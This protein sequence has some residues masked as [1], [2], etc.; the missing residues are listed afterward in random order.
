MRQIWKYPLEFAPE[1]TL[2]LPDG[3]IVRHAGFQRDTLCLWVEV[4]D[5]RA[6]PAEATVW[7]HATGDEVPDPGAAR[8]VGTVQENVLVWHVYVEAGR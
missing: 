2:V 1:Q 8:Y 6:L 7:I 3:A 5:I 4:P